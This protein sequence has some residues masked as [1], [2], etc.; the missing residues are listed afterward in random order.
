[1]STGTCIDAVAALA[2]LAAADPYTALETSSPPPVGP[3]PLSAH[4]AASATQ[5]HLTGKQPSTPVQVS[6]H[7]S[8]ASA[9][10]LLQQLLTSPSSSSTSSC[11]EVNSRATSIGQPKSVQV[12]SHYTIHQP[13]LATV[14]TVSRPYKLSKLQARG[15]RAAATSDAGSATA[16]GDLQEVTSDWT[17]IENFCSRTVPKSWL[18]LLMHAWHAVARSLTKWRCIQQVWSFSLCTMSELPLQFAHPICFCNLQ[19]QPASLICSINLPLQSICISNLP[20]KSAMLDCLFYS[21]SDMPL[22]C[23]SKLSPPTMPP[24]VLRCFCMSHSRLH[25]SSTALFHQ[26]THPV[27]I[28]NCCRTVAQ[29]KLHVCFKSHSLGALT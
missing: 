2:H 1:M 3:S 27:R 21:H 6:P 15:F 16:G 5:P 28:P 19:H 23:N 11:D 4:T 17:I 29:A 24:V 20:L 9:L 14:D 13:A 10:D 25:A 26:A 22:S 18:K 7:Q 8:T 12:K